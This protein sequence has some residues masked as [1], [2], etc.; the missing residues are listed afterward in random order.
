MNSKQLL[1]LIAY[2]LGTYLFSVSIGLNAVIIPT[3]IEENPDF[4]TFWTTLILS[5]EAIIAIILCLFVQRIIKSTGLLGTIFI[6]V[7]IRIIA[8]FL[9]SISEGVVSWFVLTLLVGVGSFIYLLFIQI[10]INNMAITRFKGMI[11]SLF[12]ILIS[13]G[14][15]TGPI[16]QSK[17]DFLIDLFDLKGYLSDYLNHGLSLSFIVSSFIT[18]LAVI[19][20]LLGKKLVPNIVITKP[21]KLNK[22]IKKSP[23]VL[24]AVALCG[25]SFFSVSW[26]ITIYGIR[27]GLGLFDSSLLLTAFM[28]GSVS[29]DGLISMLSEYVNRSYIL[30]YSALACSVLAIFLPLAIYNK[31]HAFILLFLWGG[32]ISGMYTNCLYLLEKKHKGQDSTATNA[33]FA[34][35]ENVGA[36][37]GLIMIGTL[38]NFIGTDAFSYIIIFANIAYFSFLLIQYDPRRIYGKPK[39]F[40]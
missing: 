13:L 28:L 31:Y 1:L 12:G 26:Y 8:T 7:I 29:L 38:I 6:A 23:S 36:S 22:I 16:V 17:I 40:Q 4:N 35:M 9:L 20:F 11:Y 37:F 27:N 24:F 39:S 19:P 5:I 3:F 32:I 2:F 21:R 30:V 15:A 33:A 18:V 14:I 25:I 34:L 10:C